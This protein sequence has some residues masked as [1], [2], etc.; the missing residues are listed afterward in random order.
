M[1]FRIKSPRILDFDIENRPLS[2]LG[3]DYT[4]CEIT[5]IAAS[6]GLE[7][8]IHCWLLGKHSPEFMLKNFVAMYDEADIVT[9]HY[10]RRHDLPIINGALLEYGMRPLQPKLSS[11]TKLDL[12]PIKDFSLSQESLGAALCTT[13]RKVHMTQADWRQANRLTEV[14]LAQRRVVNDVRQHQELRQR[15]VEL[16]MLNPPKLWGIGKVK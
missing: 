5:A 2:Y 16:G 4:S 8:T 3:N 13:Y 14:E 15:L 12:K 1:K 11:D 9:G 6:F 7:D 10:I